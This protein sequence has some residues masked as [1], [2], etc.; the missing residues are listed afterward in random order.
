MLMG[1][2]VKVLIK[3]KYAVTESKWKNNCSAI[4]VISDANEITKH[5]LDIA[6]AYLERKDGF[7][8]KI[9]SPLNSNPIYTKAK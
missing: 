6:K 8:K 5:N 2:Y 9:I 3:P 4:K 1:V 7:I